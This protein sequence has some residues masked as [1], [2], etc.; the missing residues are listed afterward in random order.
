MKY[1]LVIVGAGPGV[2]SPPFSLLK[3]AQR[4]NTYDRKG[5]SIEK[6]TALRQRWATVRIAVPIAI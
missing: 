1:D 5:E 2:Y 3:G 6:D 4:K